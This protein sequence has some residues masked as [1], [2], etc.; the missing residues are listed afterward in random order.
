VPERKAGRIRTLALCLIRRGDSIL[1]FE[2][3]DRVKGE[4]FYRLLGGEIEFG[5]RGAEAAVREIR[6]EIGA[7]LTDIEFRGVLESVFTYEGEPGH[8]IVL[9]YEA[10][11]EDKTLYDQERWAALEKG[12]NGRALFDVLWKPVADFREGADRLYPEGVLDVM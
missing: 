1:V 9:L 6:E 3:H 12:A 11:L 8:E 10:A 5:E 7:G 2:A 4:T